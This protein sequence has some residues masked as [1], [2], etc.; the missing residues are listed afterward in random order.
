MYTKKVAGKKALIEE[1]KFFVL[2]CSI[3][4][5]NRAQFLQK[6]MLLNEEFASALDDLTRCEL[7]MI[8]SMGDDE[9]ATNNKQE[10]D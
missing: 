4:D 5:P 7:A 8:E 9:N 3:E 6:L 2:N 10:S 1:A